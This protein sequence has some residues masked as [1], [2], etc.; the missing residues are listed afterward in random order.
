MF[1]D[2]P[3]EEWNRNVETLS[4][5]TRKALLEYQI[6]VRDTHSTIKAHTHA[7]KKGT[8]TPHIHPHCQSP[9][10]PHNP[11][12]VLSYLCASVCCVCVVL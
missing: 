9:L 5:K 12:L 10:R 4:D 11:V 1:P 6:R 3:L 2:L 8:Y 7:Q